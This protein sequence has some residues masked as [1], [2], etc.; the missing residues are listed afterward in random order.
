MNFVDENYENE[1]IDLHGKAFRGCTFTNCELV[2]DGDRP[3]TFDNNK[4][5]DTVF[6]FTDAA[7]RTL[8][9]L[10]NI[11]HAGEGGKEVIDQTFRDIRDG[12]IHGREVKTIAPHTV[13]HS[14]G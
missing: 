7:V 6:I 4:F 5:I 2:F 8:Y 9:F 10:G 11:Y 14:L 1:R 13:D 3:P 12:A